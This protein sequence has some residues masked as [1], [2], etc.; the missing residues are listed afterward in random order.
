M[1]GTFVGSVRLAN[2]IPFLVTALFA[3]LFVSERFWPLRHTQ[4]ALIGRVLINLGFSALAFLVAL[5]VV[6]PCATRALE[7]TSQLSFGLLHCCSFL[8]CG[9][10]RVSFVGFELLLLARTES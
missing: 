2:Y 6:K 10:T 7:Q 1:N 5:I 9:H 4:I 8:G 3:V